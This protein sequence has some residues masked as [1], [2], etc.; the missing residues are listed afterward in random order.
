MA[1]P[2]GQPPEMPAAV[3]NVHND[4]IANIAFAKQQQWTATNYVILLFGGAFAFS[5][6]PGLDIRCMLAVAIWGAAIGGLA[7]LYALQGGVWRG[8]SRLVA[9][10]NTWF[11]SSQQTLL[12]LPT[13]P[14]P[15]LHDWPFLLGLATVILFGAGLSSYVVLKAPVPTIERHGTIAKAIAPKP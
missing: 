2:V 12:M 5:R 7:L 11:D 1:S 6:V 14:K 4:A 15:R 10:Y 13:K 8:R 9:I 3:S